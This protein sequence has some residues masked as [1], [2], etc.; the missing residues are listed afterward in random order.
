M[1]KLFVFLFVIVLVGLSQAQWVADSYDNGVGPVA[2]AVGPKWAETA[3]LNTNFYA[4]G[5]TAQMDLFNDTTHYEGV[6]SM[7]IDYRI[8]ARDGWGGYCVRTNYHDFNVDS[9]PYID[10]ST[11]TYLK[12]RYKVLTPADTSQE[13]SV[14]MEFKI[15]EYGEGGGGGRD[16]WYHHN[17]LDFFDASGT[18][19]EV[20]M[21]LQFNTDNSLGFS[22]QFANGDGELQW[23]KVKGF[24]L[25]LVYITS[26]G[27]VN[28][29]FVTG[30]IL[31]DKLEL[32]GNRYNPFQTFDNA[33]TNVFTFDD[34][35]WAGTTG[36][37]S[38][39]LS[40][41]TTDFVEGSASM[42]LDYTVNASQD[43]GGYINLTDTTWVFP[44]SFTN[45]TALVLYVKNVNPLTG[46]TPERVTF[47][48]FLMENNTG[49]NEDWVIEV[50]VNFEQAGEWTRYYLPLKQDTVWIDS[51]GHTRFPK[52][53]FAQTWWSITGDN[54]FNQSSI[55]GYKIEFSAGG[56]APPDSYG[57]KGETFTGRILFD[58]LQQSGFKFDDNTAPDPPVVSVIP[59]SYS[60]LVT[61]LDVPGETGES[62]SV[63]YSLSPITDVAA[64]GVSLLASSIVHGTQVFEH[65]LRSANIDRPRTYY[66]A[67]TCKD[68]AGNIGSA[69]TFG[70]ITNNARGVTTV[71]INP[72]AAFV[73]DGNLGEWSGITP[74]VMSSA[75]GTANVV[76]NVSGDADCSAEAR[77]AVDANF[78]YV[79]LDVT[80]DIFNHPL[81]INPWERDEP[82]LYI[83]L[84]NLTQTHVAYGS[85]A[86]ADYQIRFDSDR[87][88]V[89]AVTDCDSLVMIGPNYYFAQKFPSGYAIEAKIPLVDL[90]TKRNFGQTSTDVID[91][92][93]GDRIPF[94]IGINDNDGSGREGMIFYSP[95]NGDQGYQNVS[96]WTFTWIG[97]EVTGI[98]DNSGLVN[99]FDLKQ[100]YPNP[101]NPSTKIQYSIAEPGLVS[102]KVFDILGRQIAELVNQQQS[103]GTY[104]VDF[105][106]QNLS[107]GV[108]MY[109]IDS[110]SF[111]ASKKMIL[112][113]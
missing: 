111:Q 41:N 74:F 48:F 90:A 96:R 6:G 101:F 9:L 3:V 21:P 17:S 14:F 4:N 56:S 71:S 30:S 36:K 62:Y 45:R 46:T 15:A 13:G 67:V 47:R 77:I 16:V 37:G 100:N 112:L 55:T 94:D 92:K 65:V 52:T 29:P 79:M 12:F 32:V 38:V 34:M 58:V 70:P 11:G 110:G 28:T 78:L 85:G 104:T 66:Y 81:D 103:A 40:N 69:G 51:A 57:P 53:G 25:A 44:D 1:K 33:A 27:T 61:W 108:Y 75:L 59:S 23:D 83:G 84:Y 102:I 97:D 10:L 105:N 64:A 35:S 106:A 82:D 72:P 60:N 24:E 26:G 68:F 107:A 8:E 19:K 49:A 54:L 95:S 91:W 63:Y 109:K 73:A 86:T 93:V 88:R 99:T 80:D 50:P 42:Q 31:I 39:V 87:I 113:K 20:M 22:N 43:W 76:L 5:L 18:W 7:K 89:D 2:G 98:D